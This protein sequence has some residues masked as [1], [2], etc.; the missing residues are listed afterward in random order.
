MLFDQKKFDI[1]ESF[2]AQN[3]TLVKFE[4][5]S[6]EIKGRMMIDLSWTERGCFSAVFT[7]PRTHRRC[8]RKQLFYLTAS[9]SFTYSN[10][11]PT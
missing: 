1:V 11:S 9:A 4:R 7:P 2:L 10:K 5:E 8:S 6:G 3:G